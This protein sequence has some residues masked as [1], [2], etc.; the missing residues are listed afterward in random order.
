MHLTSRTLFSLGLVPMAMA[1]TTPSYSYDNMGA[2]STSQN[3]T[4]NPVGYDTSR[5]GPSN[6]NCQRRACRLS[7]AGNNTMFQNVDLNANQVCPLF[8]I[9]KP[10]LNFVFSR[11]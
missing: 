2:N 10:S 7:V 6:A 5:V 8:T 11:P 3:F 9:P 1:T 4:G